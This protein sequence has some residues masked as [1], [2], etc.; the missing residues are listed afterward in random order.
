MLRPPPGKEDWACRVGSMSLA[1]IEKVA[2]IETLNRTEGNREYASKILEIG[3]RTLYRKL[4]QYGITSHDDASRW[5]Q[6]K[7]G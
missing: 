4:K 3:S 6:R 5:F 2:I 1:E 7:Q